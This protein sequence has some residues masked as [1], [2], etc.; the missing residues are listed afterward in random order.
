MRLGLAAALTAVYAY[1]RTHFGSNSNPKKHR[2]ALSFAHDSRTLG[3]PSYRHIDP[4][5]H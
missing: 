3:Y 2:G 5:T 1:H 4:G